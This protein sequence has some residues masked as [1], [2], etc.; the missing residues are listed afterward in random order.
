MGVKLTCYFSHKSYLLHMIDLWWCF[1]MRRYTL[2]FN[3]SQNQESRRKTNKARWSNRIAF[4]VL[5]IFLRGRQ[6]NKRHSVTSLHTPVRRIRKIKRC[7]CVVVYSY[8]VNLYKVAYRSA[9]IPIPGPLLSC[10]QTPNSNGVEKWSP[11]FV[12]H[13]CWFVCFAV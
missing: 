3:A 12:A 1:Y 10:H 5:H 6:T 8:F 11:P 7:S 13:L 9:S 4:L 2:Y